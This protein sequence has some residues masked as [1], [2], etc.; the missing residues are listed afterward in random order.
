MAGRP[1]SYRVHSRHPGGWTLLDPGVGDVHVTGRL[2][3]G[4]I[5]TVSMLAGTQ[6]GDL[7]TFAESH[8]P[9]GLIVYIQA[10]GNR[11]IADPATTSD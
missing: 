5:Q 11:A 4:C 1:Y 2:I 7:K 3:G 9:E 8:A 10:G 6:Y